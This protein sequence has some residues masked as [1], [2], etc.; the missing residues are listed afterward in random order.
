[1]TLSMDPKH[2]KRYGRIASLLV[3]H[4]RSDVVRRAGLEPSLDGDLPEAAAEPGTD[5]EMEKRA[6][7]LTDELEAMGPTFV[8]L[9]QLLSTRVDLL[10]P[11]YIHALARLQDRVDPFPFEE[12]ERIV[13]DELGV[14]LSKAFESFEREPVAAASL[15]QV[16][17][18]VLRDGR[19]VA[20]KVQRPGIRARVRED[21]EALEE[22]A[23]F[24][25]DHSDTAHRYRLAEVIDHFRR[26]LIRELDYRSEARNL[27][28]LAANLAEMDT[29][30]VPKPVESYSTARVLT[31]ELVKG[32]KVTALSPLAL[33]ELDRSRLAEDLFRAYLK[34]ILVDGFFHADPHPGNVFIT[35][36]QKIALLDLGM[37]ATVSTRLR[38]QL[39]RL[40][41]A[42]ADAEADDAAEVLIGLSEPEEDADTDGFTREV[43]DLVMRTEGQTAS[44][45]A[46]G[47]VVLE[48]VR[49]AGEHHISP[50]SELAM[51]GK[52]LLNLDE[53]GRTL[54]PDF[55]PNAA[56]RRNAA[57]L[58]ERRM[59]E[60]VSPSSL[61][62]AALEA[63]ELVQQM[64]RR[65][66]RI[67]EMLSENRL[68]L[69]VEAVDEVRLIAGLEKIA[70]RI[71]LGLVIAAL[72]MGAAMLVRVDGGPEILGYPALALVFFLAAAI[73][74]ITL[75]LRI[76][77]RDRE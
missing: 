18:A 74:G 60:S 5:A 50:P 62:K 20:V 33:M 76:V 9:G 68:T 32:R 38:E 28:T 1:M 11:A 22:L 52:T 29:I 72:I 70:N 67:L 41:L 37:T 17:R 39:L 40:L 27:D 7:S 19:A 51:L 66:N 16:H 45:V 23:G 65:L 69:N 42:V 30:C 55:E 2:L 35:D 77:L 36:D 57:A 14:R 73:A 54:D 56:I 58:M 63:N 53:V 43:E 75:A 8:K 25:D 71:T 49:K 61:L 31:M 13:S 12:V 26:S 21:L 15:G 48:L 44:E 64:P 59:M 46:V 34:Q 47:A 10:P 6:A 3:R 4:G 24:L